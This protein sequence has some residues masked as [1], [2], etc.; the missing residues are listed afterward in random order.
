MT[1]PTGTAVVRVGTPGEQPNLDPIFVAGIQEPE[2]VYDNPAHGGWGTPVV[3]L[4]G[5]GYPSSW[6]RRDDRWVTYDGKVIDAQGTVLGVTSDQHQAVRELHARGETPSIMWTGK[7]VIA[8]ES[9]TE[10]A[11]RIDNEQERQRFIHDGLADI[12]DQIDRL[13]AEIQALAIQLGRPKPTAR[14]TQ[15]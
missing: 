12:E 4:N 8:G 2:P 14:P 3:T 11:N 15:Q 9:S 13:K 7:Q 1:N 6:S 5:A 10:T